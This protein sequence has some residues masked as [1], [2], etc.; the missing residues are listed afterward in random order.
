MS[1]QFRFKSFQ[2]I[3]TVP[4]PYKIWSTHA[5]WLPEQQQQTLPP[6][7]LACNVVGESEQ[8]NKKQRTHV[9][10][11]SKPLL[12]RQK[13]ATLND[14]DDESIHGSDEECPGMENFHPLYETSLSQEDVP[15]KGIKWITSPLPLEV[16]PM[17]VQISDKKC[18]DYFRESQAMYSHITNKCQPLNP[19]IFDEN[20]MA[21][22]SCWRAR[23]LE[24]AMW[25]NQQEHKQTLEVFRWPT[26]WRSRAINLDREPCTIASS[27]RIDFSPKQ[28]ILCHDSGKH[29]HFSK[30]EK[31]SA[32][33][34]R[35]LNENAILQSQVVAGTY[36]IFKWI[37]KT[38]GVTF[39]DETHEGDAGS[40]KDTSGDSFLW[41]AHV[42]SHVS[43]R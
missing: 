30:A 40:S 15:F 19:S 10:G 4:C 9:R 11:A 43:R 14:T 25:C 20:V 42:L 1:H 38:D 28:Q 12:K 18:A 22:W 2:G 33:K 13:L 39:A 31:L 23:A 21:H 6:P 8:P 16:V 27:E 29:G 34:S 24:E 36:V 41:L 17:R 26:S 35:S 5:V 37:D 32:A 3:R 7:D